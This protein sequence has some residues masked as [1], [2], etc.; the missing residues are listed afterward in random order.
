MSIDPMTTGWEKQ[1]SSVWC[2]YKELTALQQQM[3]LT[4][5]HIQNQ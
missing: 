1:A 5:G 4:N 2:E 3:N